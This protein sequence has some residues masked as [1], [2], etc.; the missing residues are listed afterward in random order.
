V[1][2]GS[3]GPMRARCLARLRSSPHLAAFADIIEAKS[4]TDKQ[5]RG[6]RGD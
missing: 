6:D 2:V 3:I 5:V 1:A 4:T